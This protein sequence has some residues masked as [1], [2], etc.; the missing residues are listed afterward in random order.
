[1]TRDGPPPPPPAVT[2]TQGTT[3]AKPRRHV[4][5]VGA[6]SAPHV[7]IPVEEDNGDEQNAVE[8]AVAAMGRGRRGSTASKTG[9]SS[10]GDPFSN[11]YR[12]DDVPISLAGG[13]EDGA[14]EGLVT[15]F[16]GQLDVWLDPLERDGL[17]ALAAASAAEEG[18]DPEAVK[19]ENERKARELLRAT[20]GGFGL[21]DGLRQRRASISA[22]GKR[23]KDEEKAA[24]TEQDPPPDAGFAGVGPGGPGILSALMALSQ[25]EVALGEQVDTPGSSVAP[26]PTASH[27]GSPHL[28]SLT[29]D[30]EST[31]DEDERE[32]FI[33]RLRAKRASKNAV[34]H[35]SSS[36][37]TASK[38]AARSAASAAFRA[39]TGGF[40]R[41]HERGRSNGSSRT[42]STATLSRLAEERSPSRSPTSP[43][44]PASSSRALSPVR[45]PGTASSAGSASETPAPSSPVLASH[46]RSLSSNT[47]S[48]LASSTS[49]SRL[50][51]GSASP[52]VSP[53]EVGVHVPHRT[54]FSSELN[55]RV[56]KLGDRLGL[57]LETERTRPNAARSGAGVFGGLVLGAASLATPATPSGAALAPLPTR[58][59]YH[60]SR[61]SAPDVRP[62][63]AS[64]TASRAA[65]RAPS[66]A[67]SPTGSPTPSTHHRALSPPRR[68]G[69]GSAPP[70]S[71]AA[72][73]FDT[74]SRATSRKSLS[75]MV[76]EE[77]EEQRNESSG[78]GNT[79][80]PTPPSVQ[81]L[82]HRRE[83][84]KKAV[85][86][87][88]LND[89]PSATD[90][91]FRQASPASS[92]PSLSI[93]TSGLQN[94]TRQ[95]PSPTSGSGT[96]RFF[97]PRTPGQRTPGTASPK[98]EYFDT[99][100][101]A[102]AAEKERERA[103][104]KALEAAEREAREREQDLKEWQK[105]KRRRRKAR[106]KEL[107]ARRVFITAHVAALLERQEFICKLARSFMMF[108]APTHRLEAQIQATARVLELPHC[109]CLYLPNLLLVNFGDPH[110]MTS[111]IKFLKQPSGLDFSKLKT[112]YWIYHRV[113]RDKLSVTEASLKLDEL[114]TSPP[115]YPLW[116]HVLTGG[117]AGA[118]I[119]PSAFYGSFIDCLMA[120]PLGGMLVL[121]Q[122]F[123][124]RNDFY[125]SLFE[126]VVCVLNAVIAGALSYTDYFCFYSI[127][128]G[129]IV[130]ILPGFIFLCAAL[131]IANRSIVSGAS[132]IAYAA[133]YSLFLGFGLS[134]GAEVY[135][136]GGR[137]QVAGGGDYTCAY[138]RRD[139]PW[140]RATI[141]AWWYF[142]SIPLFLIC[143]AIKNGQHVFRRDT[144]VM[145]LI[146]CAGFSTNFFSGYAF[147]NMPAL[148]SSLGAFVVGILGN[149]WSRLT[150]ESAFVVMIVG[151][152]VQLPS[153]LANGG[154]ISFAQ[155]STS[156]T[157][158]HFSS[159]VNAAAGI[160]RVIVGI[161]V[162]LFAAAAVVNLVSRRGRRRGAHLS[163]F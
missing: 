24:T 102:S 4:Q 25:Q 63:T 42:A 13:K 162:G 163:T 58:P 133:L 76:R 150:R 14:L 152:F 51:A 35:A 7:A 106:E 48:R 43:L 47:L 62:D 55:K 104:R 15:P 82:Q 135:T 31:D 141:P 59:G 85:F 121:V 28:R 60:L 37:A 80:L 50:S 132:R 57:E 129:S 64:S 91:D 66:R 88:Q 19:Q 18:P 45:R 159:A 138:I 155:S 11:R 78:G 128:A 146:G 93:S 90:D 115:L 112:T 72:R 12:V 160:V 111:D 145:V 10:D 142:L 79:P 86:S 137:Q 69:T 108:G 119:M 41:G 30:P 56:R 134:A 114:M 73:S 38:T 124:A 36:L 22:L 110:T 140:Y 127:A 116:V 20:T 5:F 143:M 21:W 101:P 105:E 118:A 34:H 125:S 87:L 136:L 126:I 44:S 61:F 68:P 49:L 89:L 32:R 16:A 26:T 107:K 149:A 97:A 117:V 74:N 131:E 39:A 147:A 109:T 81:A 52:P 6:V 151:L 33:A 153:G 154:L 122:V 2:D 8:G 123:L 157:S 99:L 83:R 75:D 77:E 27:P 84:R 94:K 113:I 53:V 9:S 92:R 144:L 40:T 161:T 139:A 71:P 23:E 67:P 148:T 54:K 17:P 158:N 130:L 98:R 96:Y 1:M 3:A 29:P 65:S 103:V 100:S 95:T 156:R 46:H 70:R 120:V